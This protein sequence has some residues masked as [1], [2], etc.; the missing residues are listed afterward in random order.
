MLPV[1]AAHALHRL[2]IAAAD[3]RPPVRPFPSTFKRVRQGHSSGSAPDAESQ[4]A[5]TR[6]LQFWIII[7]TCQFLGSIF[8]SRFLQL[9]ALLLLALMVPRYGA[10]LTAAIFEAATPAL[11]WCAKKTHILGAHT[12]R[13]VIKG[14]LALQSTVSELCLGHLSAEE[15]DLMEQHLQRT[16]DA[17]QGAIAAGGGGNNSKRR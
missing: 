7:S 16:H 10:L 2:S 4:E 3:P 1:R 14:N 8:W 17:C 12:T 5:R 11:A 6:W 13:V 15:L 9:R